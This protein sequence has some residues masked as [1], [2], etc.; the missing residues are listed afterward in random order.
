M[1]EK[2]IKEDN[3]ARYKKLPKWVQ[4][5]LSRL[6]ADVNYYKIKAYEVTS[7]DKSNVIVD[8]GINTDKHK[9]LPKNTEITFVMSNKGEIHI[10]LVADDT[11]SVHAS[12]DGLSSVYITPYSGN[13]FH[14]KA[15]TDK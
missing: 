13:L 9:Y 14:I 11:L 4:Q 10:R 2:S 1:T 6:K 12:M 3:T 5:E 15:I 7:M 8:K